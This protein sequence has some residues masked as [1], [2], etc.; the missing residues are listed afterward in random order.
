MNRALFS[1]ALL[2]LATAL[3]FHL[4]QLHWLRFLLAFAVIDLVGYLPGA[5]AF[6]RAD[7]GRIA[8]LYH[9]LYNLTHSFLTAAV[10]I[11]LWAAISGFE[12]AMLAIPLHLCGDRAIFGNGPKPAH[13]PFERH[14]PETS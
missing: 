8:P 9:H 3:L 4:G 2:V 7:G 10:V 6:R 13:L 12:W 14:A 11:G 1:A 5:R